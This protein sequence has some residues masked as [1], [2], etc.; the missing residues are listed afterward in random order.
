MIHICTSYTVQ[1][2]LNFTQACGYTRARTHFARVKVYNLE[3]IFLVALGFVVH[4]RAIKHSMHTRHAPHEQTRHEHTL[5][6]PST[7]HGTPHE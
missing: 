1:L 5:S 7:T 4:I 6:Y 3:C 2:S